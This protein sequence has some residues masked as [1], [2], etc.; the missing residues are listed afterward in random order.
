MGKKITFKFYTVLI[1]LL[2]GWSV[3]AQDYKFSHIGVEQ[4]LSQSVVNCMLQDSKGFMWFGTQEGLNRYDGYNFKVFKRDPQNSNSIAGN[5]IYTLFEDKNGISWIG[6]NGNGLD[7]YNP[8]LETFTH[9]ANDPEN[10]KSISDNAVRVIYQDYKGRLWFGTDKGLNLF[11]E[12]TKTFTRFVNNEND[13][14]SLSGDHI[15]SI[16]EDVQKNLWVSTYENGLNLFDESKRQFLNYQPTQDDANQLYPK[17]F[18]SDP[19]LVEQMHQV[20]VIKRMSDGNF[21]LGADGAGLEIFNPSS[22][23]FIR[24]FYPTSDTSSLLNDK[25]IFDIETDKNGQIWLATYKGGVNVLSSDFKTSQYYLP[26]DKDPFAIKGNSI[27]CV[28]SDAQGNI[29]IGSN[30]N[31]IDVYFKQTSL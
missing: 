19:E 20:R 13:E 16:I 14:R 15:Y 1:G 22:R 3:R 4:G 6:T 17:A 7:A 11:D 21:L 23:R 29:W 27:R 2:V 10:V 5:F 31:G 28:F 30:G 9:Y 8:V 18:S 26:N 24:A 25:R 12:S